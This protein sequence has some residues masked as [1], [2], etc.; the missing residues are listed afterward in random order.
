MG[1][2]ARVV[3]LFVSVLLKSVLSS[4]LVNLLLVG[5]ICLGRIFTLFFSG[6]A[7]AYITLSLVV[8]AT[9]SPMPLM[10]TSRGETSKVNSMLFEY[11]KNG[12]TFSFEYSG[13][14]MLRLLNKTDAVLLALGW[15]EVNAFELILNVHG[16]C[17][18]GVRLPASYDGHA[19]W[20]REQNM[21]TALL[22]AVFS[23]KETKARGGRLARLVLTARSVSRIDSGTGATRTILEFADESVSGNSTPPSISVQITTKGLGTP[24]KCEFSRNTAWVCRQ[25]ALDVS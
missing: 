9:P 13:H 5:A 1:R 4:L 17:S 2:T 21:I 11:K 8:L 20:E 24:A 3:E 14:K 19:N 22:A 10:L 25:H 12:E 6:V 16:C 23:S 18:C 15:Q 7:F